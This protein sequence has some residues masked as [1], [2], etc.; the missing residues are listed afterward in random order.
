MAGKSNLPADADHRP[1]LR[2]T[3]RATPGLTAL[4]AE[5]EASMA[6]EGGAAGAVMESED[7][8]AVPALATAV[9]APTWSGSRRG[10]AVALGIGAGALLVALIRSR[11]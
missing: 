5:R 10:R 8:S 6:D 7:E 4:D 2:G 9:A 1:S 11:R 3:S